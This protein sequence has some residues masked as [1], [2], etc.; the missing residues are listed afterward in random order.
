MALVD[1]SGQILHMMAQDTTTSRLRRM[2]PA[3]T[4]WAY[5]VHSQLLI[6]RPIDDLVGPCED[7]TTV[8]HAPFAVTTTTISEPSTSLFPA[9]FPFTP[10]ITTISVTASD[11]C[12]STGTRPEAAHITPSVH[13]NPMEGETLWIEGLPMG[14]FPYHIY[15]TTGKL[16]LSGQW[17]SDGALDLGPLPPGTYLLEVVTLAQRHRWLLVR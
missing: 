13:P 5:Y 6:R 15:D 2:L 10:D 14:V 1:T 4:S 3:D 17:T 9:Q 11:H 7:V 12:I 8:T 16:K